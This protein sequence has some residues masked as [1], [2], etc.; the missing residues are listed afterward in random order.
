MQVNSRQQAQLNLPF[1]FLEVLVSPR[2]KVKLQK[3]LVESQLFESASKVYVVQ[4]FRTRELSVRLRTINNAC[5]AMASLPDGTPLTEVSMYGSRDRQY[6]AGPYDGI[7]RLLAGELPSASALQN[8]ISAAQSIIDQSIRELASWLSSLTSDGRVQNVVIQGHL[9]QFLPVDSKYIREAIIGIE[10]IKT[11]L[12]KLH[13]EVC[14]WTVWWA[15]WGE[16][17]ESVLERIPKIVA[18]REGI[19]DKFA[20]SIIPPEEYLAASK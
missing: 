12:Q 19:L 11:D 4:E 5:D 7:K 14:D 17:A 8:E 13:Q 2:E 6:L 15:P 9:T 20:Q 1:E 10:D 18:K 16:L 3:G